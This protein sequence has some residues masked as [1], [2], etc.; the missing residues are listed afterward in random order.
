[1]TI[2]V[3]AFCCYQINL[4]TD[5]KSCMGCMASGDY[6]CFN[7]NM[8][9]CKVGQEHTTTENALCLFQSSECVCIKP[10]TCMM[11]EGQCFCLDGAAAFPCNEKVP[12]ALTYCGL[13]ICYKYK[14]V[15][16]C[17]KDMKQGEEGGAP[18]KEITDFEVKEITDVEAAEDMDRQ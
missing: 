2:P 7:G 1:M 16:S 13:V 10:T 11:I 15:C 6:C 18:A 9:A 5:L 8:K 12:C 14:L 3:F 4:N 17:C